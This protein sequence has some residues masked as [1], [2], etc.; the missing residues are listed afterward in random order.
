[1]SEVLEV[2]PRGS[3]PYPVHLGAGASAK[4]GDSLPQGCAAAAVISD[5]NVA[6]LH[7]GIIGEILS[8]R[9][10]VE[11]FSFP[12]GEENKTR[13]VKEQVEDGMVGR[14]LGRDCV[15]VALGGGVTVDLAGFVASTYLRGVPWI[16]V[17]TSLL[18][19]VDAGIGGKTGVNTTAGKNLVGTFH[20]PHA[21]L[22]DLN[23]LATLPPGEVDNGLAEMVKHAVIADGAYLDELESAAAGLRR[24]DPAALAGPVRRSVEIKARVVAGDPTEED[25]RQVLNC[26]HTI[27]HALEVVSDYKI[28]HGKAVAAGLSVEA[29]IARRLGLLDPGEMLRLRAALKSL[30]LPAAPPA[31]LDPEALLRATRM[32]KKGRQGRVRYALPEALGKMARG[33]E[34]YGH[35]VEDRVVL[36]ALREVRDCSA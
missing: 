23:L 27:A 7:A 30:Q 34:G 29:D 1:M 13:R 25:L 16:A 15:V 32:D 17:P 24:L 11:T 2:R 20:Q 8:E 6:G 10:R 35:P 3:R 18:A 5:E 33:P 4:L 28:N 21:V 31:D 12:A 36:E 19:A 14:G 9:V 26:G 22:I